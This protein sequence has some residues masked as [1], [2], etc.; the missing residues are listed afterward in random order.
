MQFL[1]SGDLNFK[2]LLPKSIDFCLLGVEEH[3]KE[4]N[5]WNGFGWVLNCLNGFEQ[6]LIVLD[7]F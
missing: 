2:L 6:F 3:F 4:W 5:G 1:C 7:V